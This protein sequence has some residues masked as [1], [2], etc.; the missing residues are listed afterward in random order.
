VSGTPL[1]PGQNARV[2]ALDGLTLH[3]EPDDSSG[4]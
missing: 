1:A 3:V 4:R 2:I